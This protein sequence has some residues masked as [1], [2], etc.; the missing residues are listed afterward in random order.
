MI[1]TQQ[2]YIDDV[3]FPIQCCLAELAEKRCKKMWI[4]ACVDDLTYKINLLYV[5]LTRLLRQNI[6]DE[7][8]CLTI[9]EINRILNRIRIICGNC[10]VARIAT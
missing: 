5:Y 4:G 10:C 1:T 2:Q 7:D 6:E 3:L 9:D 8:P